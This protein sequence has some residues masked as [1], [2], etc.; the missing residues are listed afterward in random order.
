MNLAPLPFW[1]IPPDLLPS[2]HLREHFSMTRSSSTPRAS[3]K[4]SLNSRRARARS[5]EAVS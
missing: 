2:Y 5:Y 4:S 1:P 3:P